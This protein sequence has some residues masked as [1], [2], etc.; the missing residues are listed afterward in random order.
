MY[1][2][3]ETENFT[4]SLEQD[5]G[6]QRNKIL[7]KLRDYVY[8]Q[9]KISPEFGQNIKKLR[10]WAPPTWR[11]RIGAYR[12]FFEI[13]NEQQIVFMIVAEHRRKAYKK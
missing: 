1:K 11:Y 12:F 2:I 7:K 9:L 10:E 8:P 5:F 13:D 3:F 4:K 6:G